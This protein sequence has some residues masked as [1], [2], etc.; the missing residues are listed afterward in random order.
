MMRPRSSGSSTSPGSADYWPISSSHCS[1]CAAGAESS[2]GHHWRRAASFASLALL[3]EIRLLKVSGANELGEPNG[4]PT[5]TGFR[6]RQA[7]S[8]HG[9]GWQMPHRAMS[10]HV[11]RRYD[12]VLQARGPVQQHVQQRRRPTL[13][14]NGSTWSRWDGVLLARPRSKEH[15]G[16][17][18]EPPPGGSAVVQCDSPPR[19]IRRRLAALTGS[20]GA[21]LGASEGRHRATPGHVQRLSMQVDATSGDARRRRAMVGMCFGSRRPPVR[22][23]PSRPEAQVTGLSGTVRVSSKIF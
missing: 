8:S 11:Q 7:T 4:E 5:S 13:T 20:L 14:G 3:G 10:S 6:P 23:R 15:R 2:C 1:W 16:R 17:R 18:S 12:L 21:K 9:R 22:I 19:P